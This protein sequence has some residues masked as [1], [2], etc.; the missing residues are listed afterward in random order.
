[1]FSQACIT[2]FV[3]SEGGVC[4]FPECITG[5]MIILGG[6]PSWGWGVFPPGKVDPPPPRLADPTPNTYVGK[7]PTPRNTVKGGRYAFYWNA[8]LFYVN[9]KLFNNSEDIITARVVKR[10]KV[11]LL[12]A[13]VTHSVQRGRSETPKVSGQ[14]LPPWDQ[15]RTSTPSPPPG[16][17]S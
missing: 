11:M 1:M 10:V 4:L 2:H 8:F 14:H 3:N 13:C 17:W 5:H 7:P 12:Q 16:T 6:L 9:L 15:V